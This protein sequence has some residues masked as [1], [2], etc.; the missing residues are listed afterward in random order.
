MSQIL[1]DTWTGLNVAVLILHW[2][3]NAGIWI[4]PALCSQAATFSSPKASGT[5][6]GTAG[7]RFP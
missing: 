5:L 6:L 3:S 2:G 4:G 7:P 1:A